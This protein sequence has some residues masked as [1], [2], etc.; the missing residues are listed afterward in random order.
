METIN[1]IILP[2]VVAEAVRRCMKLTL[3]GICDYIFY[4]GWNVLLC[5]LSG[6]FITS[7]IQ[8]L[9]LKEI[10]QLSVTYTLLMA[11][12]YSIVCFLANLILKNISLKVEYRS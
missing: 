9:L 6:H 7:V 3:S 1:L 2:V 5:L 4:Y 8:S 11:L 12:C 10:P